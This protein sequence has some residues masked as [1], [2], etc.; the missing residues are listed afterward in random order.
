MLEGSDQDDGGPSDP[1]QP[2]DNGCTDP[3]AVSLAEAIAA[4]SRAGE[5]RVVADLASQ[6]EKRLR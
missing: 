4:A 3:I 5:W 1:L 6:L 2:I